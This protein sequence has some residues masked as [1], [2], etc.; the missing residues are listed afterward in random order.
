MANVL[1]YLSLKNIFAAKCCSR[2]INQLVCSR[3]STFWSKI[4][5]QQCM[6]PYLERMD[7]DPGFLS[8]ILASNLVQ[9]AHLG[10]TPALACQL[11]NE[12]GGRGGGLATQNTEVTQRFLQL[13]SALARMMACANLKQTRFASAAENKRLEMLVA[14]LPLAKWDNVRYY[15]AL[16]TIH[17]AEHMPKDKAWICQKYGATVLIQTPGG[18]LELNFVASHEL[19]EVVEERSVYCSVSFPGQSCSTPLLH[20]RAERCIEE[21]N[22]TSFAPSV[23][24]E[25]WHKL[26]CCFFGQEKSSISSTTTTVALVFRLLSAPV[27]AWQLDNWRSECLGRSEGLGRLNHP[28]CCGCGTSLHWLLI[29]L[30][31]TLQR[32]GAAPWMDRL[33]WWRWGASLHP[34]EASVQLSCYIGPASTGLPGG[35]LGKLRQ[36]GIQTC[37]QPSKIV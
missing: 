33:P 13:D 4:L 28:P 35:E 11:G 7:A 1:S 22:F 23:D 31:P 27:T 32:L 17:D 21:E 10:Q 34:A 15:D 29:V 2:L 16:V 8:S 6:V 5:F 18:K 19:T 37:L 30:A 24:I 36:L 3:R 9:W 26:H 20:T 12:S 14:S 25:E